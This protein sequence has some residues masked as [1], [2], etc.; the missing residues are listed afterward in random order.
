MDSTKLWIEKTFENVSNELKLKIEKLVKSG[1]YYLCEECDFVFR[2]QTN[3]IPKKCPKCN[4]KALTLL[5]KKDSKYKRVI[6]L[7]KEWP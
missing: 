4:S 7:F 5:E 3:E 2:A 1:A 6:V